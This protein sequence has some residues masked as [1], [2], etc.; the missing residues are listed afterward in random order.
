MDEALLIEN[1]TF[2]YLHSDEPVLKN[3]NLSIPRNKI[4]AIVGVVGSGKTTLLM[5]MNGLI[6]QYF[7]GKLDGRVVVDGI[8]VSSVETEQLAQTINM[9]FDDPDLQIVA[10][11][12]EE[13]VA[14]G[15]A[16]FGLP[17][18]E[19]WERVEKAL[20]RMR[21]QGYEK[22]NPRQ[23]SGGEKQLLAMAGI[24]A[25]EPK[26]IAMDE[27]VAMLDPQGKRLVFDTLQYINQDRGLTTIVTESGTDIEAVCEF[28]DHMVVLHHGEVIFQGPPGEVF[29]R[30]EL[31]EKTAMRVPQVTRVFWQLGFQGAQIPVNLDDAV[32]EIRSRYPGINSPKSPR[33]NESINHPIGDPMV[34][35]SN[36]H[37]IFPS[38]PPVHA[39]RGVNLILRQGEL[40]ALLGQNGS[41]KSTLALHLANI[42][43]PT[44]PEAQI[45]AGGVD[46][47]K[48][49]TSDT[50]KI[51]NY[52]FQNP[53][54][55]L[56]CQKFGEEVAYGPI[57]MGCEPAEVTRRVDKALNEVG[58][59]DLKDEYESPLTRAESTLLSFAS[60]LSIEPPV[61]IADEPTGGLDEVTGRKVIQ[62]LLE[63]TLAGETVMMITHDMELA[64]SFATRIIVMCKGQI[65]ADDTPRRVFANQEVLDRA[66][67]VPP[68]VTRLALQTGLC[69]PA[70][71]PITV[72]EF[73]SLLP[74][75]GNESEGE[76]S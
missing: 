48:A 46:V 26:I 53:K 72:D 57:Q 9:I 13:D 41:G 76:P 18:T 30:K 47:V 50:I 35:G 31:I 68:A 60:V 1:L 5:T 21:M 59:L 37:H 55:Q 24:F 12:V 54:N 36:I 43:K 39:L 74:E 10:N 34:T 2:T 7:P 63:K 58:L 23:L 75:A 49:P 42:L 66:Y 38:Y 64:A 11:T 29:A 61:I 27:P 4:T 20:A 71:V 8:D 67:L 14:F 3:I 22:R 32:Q 51:I 16:N 70:Q 40:V 65:I 62:L 44:N 56:F 28:A 45:S 69:D 6:P 15:P 19:I 25:M 33:V 73:I 52:I 17:C